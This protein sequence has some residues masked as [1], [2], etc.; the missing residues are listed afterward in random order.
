MPITS[1]IYK[2]IFIIRHIKIKT[3]IPQELYFLYF[4]SY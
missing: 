3:F 2:H 4:V 1:A